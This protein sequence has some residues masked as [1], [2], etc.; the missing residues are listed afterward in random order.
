MATEGT[1]PVRRVILAALKDNEA[2]T[3]IVP[4]GSIHPQSPMGIPTWPFVNYGSPAGIPLEAACVDGDVIT[5]AVHSF[6]KR[7]ENG[8]GQVVETAE[9]HADRIGTAV[10]RALHRKRLSLP[11][12]AFVKVRRRGH[13]LLRDGAEK[14]AYHH[15][16][17]FEVR[18]LS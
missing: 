4:E 6:A 1:V 5:V 7:R 2:L 16:A 9:D 11:S 18:V 17:N 3:D 15:V 12:G 13:Q 10:M 8:A 14:D